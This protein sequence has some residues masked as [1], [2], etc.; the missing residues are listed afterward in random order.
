MLF[1]SPWSTG[2]FTVT[3]T[4][5]RSPPSVGSAPVASARRELDQGISVTLGTGAQ[6][7]FDVGGR[8]G[9][10]QRAQRRTEDLGDLLIRPSG[11]LT[12][13]IEVAQPQPPPRL[14]RVFGAR[15]VLVKVG[16]DPLAQH[17]Q[18]PAAPPARR[19]AP[20]GQHLGGGIN[21]RPRPPADRTPTPLRSYSGPASI[22]ASYR[23]HLIDGDLAD[24]TV[25]GWIPGPAG[26]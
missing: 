17:R 8:A 11:Q 20:A 1:R 6:I 26:R 14:G 13:P 18:L 4:W 3:T 24:P 22:T 9:R 5:G 10:G 21:P 16:E 25:L 19:R 12:A 23:P 15:A 2:R 7:D